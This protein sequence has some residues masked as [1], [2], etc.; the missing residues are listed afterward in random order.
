MRQRLWLFRLGA[1][2]QATGY[3]VQI[4]YVALPSAELAVN[5]VA[6]RVKHGGHNIPQLDIERR[7]TRS[8]HNLFELYIPLADRW[9]VLDNSTGVLNT[10]A[11]GSPKRTLVIDKDVW[12][13]LKQLAI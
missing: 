8:L 9:T 1:S 2:C 5:R 4:Y 11:Q 3:R 7:F 6:L 10:V 13:K 12:L